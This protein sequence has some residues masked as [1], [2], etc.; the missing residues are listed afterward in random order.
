MRT[1]ILAAAMLLTIQAAYAGPPDARVEEYVYSH[2]GKQHYLMTAFNGEKALLAQ[3]EYSNIYAKSGRSFA[4]W[5]PSATG[6]PDTTIAVVRFIVPSLG[7]RLYVKDAE[8]A[9]LRALPQTYVEEGIA[10]Y[11]EPASSTGACPA[12]Q[13]AIYR[14]SNNRADTN[15][16]YSTDVYEHAAMVASGFGNEGV[17]FCSHS[18]G[19]DLDQE[20]AAGT[21]RTN[22]GKTTLTGVI[23]A[24]SGYD[25]QVGSQR[26]DVHNARLE[27]SA[28]AG[29]TAGTEVAVEGALINGTVVASDV[30]RKNGTGN[31]VTELE[32][33]VT[34]ATSLSMVYVNGMVV[35]LS[36]VTSIIP[37]VGSRISV[38][39]VFSNGVFTASV[40]VTNAAYSGSGDDALRGMDSADSL[41]IK[42]A[43]ANYAGIGSFTVNGQLVNAVNAIFEYR[44][45]VALANAMFVELHGNLVSG[46]FVATRID[47]KSAAYTSDSSHGAY[48]EVKGFVSDFASLRSFKVAG[49]SVD[50]SAAFFKNGFPAMLRNGVR[51]EVKGST[52][53]GVLKAAEVE[54]SSNESNG[55]E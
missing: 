46:V 26:V 43:I 24:A 39:G 37:A 12:G 1:K 38:S 15:Y 6:R 28:L 16:R 2:A 29:L 4:A 22:E 25:L 31:E 27:N 49:L 32:G 18:V 41:E 11:A 17:E 54:F 50:A 55:G 36:R 42:G 13:K 33:Y 23:T 9:Q 48:L 44:T 45:G 3:P 21:P 20:D 40:L 52:A 8:A 7:L 34:A 30:S 14:A 47:V 5:S 53:S 10:F 35:D 51:V 19:V